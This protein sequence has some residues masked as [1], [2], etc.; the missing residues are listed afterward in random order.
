MIA[1]RKVRYP[2]SDELRGYLQQFDR[3]REIPILYDDLT[4]FSGAVPYEDPRGRETLWLT[5]MYP[6]E[7]F[8]ELRPRLI[9]IY[10]ELKLGRHAEQHGHLAVDRIDYGDFGNSRPFGIRVT[11]LFLEGMRSKRWGRIVFLSTVGATRPGDRIPEY[12]AAKGALPSVTVSLAKFLANSG[13]TVNCVS[14]GLIATAEMIELFTE[15]A[16]RKGLPTDWSSVE[17]MILEAGM[18][19]PSGQ[20]PKPDDV[21]RFVAFVVSESAWHLNGAHLRFDGG[22]ADAV[23]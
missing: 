14:P 9:A 13:I 11:N 6:Q 19:N 15:R 16:R 2:V 3:Q 10:T 18:T 8:A 5:V 1:Q 7:V 21:G 22:A 20:I 12:Y 4:R 17:Q 23:T